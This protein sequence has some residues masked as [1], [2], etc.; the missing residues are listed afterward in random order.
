[1]RSATE[2][3]RAAHRISPDPVNPLPLFYGVIE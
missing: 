2:R 3:V 1:M